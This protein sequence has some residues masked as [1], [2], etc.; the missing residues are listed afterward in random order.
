M[1]PRLGLT[2]MLALGRRLSLTPIDLEL[3]L[4][5]VLEE[6]LGVVLGVDPKLVR[7]LVYRSLSPLSYRL[8][9]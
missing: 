2:F 6:V 1:L 3:V 9:Y 8:L 4:E 7:G 5:L